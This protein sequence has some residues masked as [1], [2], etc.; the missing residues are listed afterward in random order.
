VAIT[1]KDL[2]NASATIKKPLIQMLNKRYILMLLISIFIFHAVYMVYASHEYYLRIRLENWLLYSKQCTTDNCVSFE[3]LMH[4]VMDNYGWKQIAMAS[5]NMLAISIMCFLISILALCGSWMVSRI[6]RV[7]N[8]VG[9]CFGISLILFIAYIS[10]IINRHFAI[11]RP[12][13]RLGDFSLGVTVDE[14]ILTAFYAFPAFLICCFCYELLRGRD[15][16]H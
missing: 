16:D 3:T 1:T 14:R 13:F 7:G 9:A 4:R 12:E 6:F 11:W 5:L 8:S 2:S 15:P 10:A